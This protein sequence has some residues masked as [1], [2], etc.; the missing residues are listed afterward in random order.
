[1]RLKLRK[2]S[3]LIL[4]GLDLVLHVRIIFAA[5]LQQGDSILQFIHVFDLRVEGLGVRVEILQQTIP[6]V[7]HKDKKDQ[8]GS[9]RVKKSGFAT[10]TMRLLGGSIQDSS[11]SGHFRSAGR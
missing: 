3:V 1:M 5:L 8:K 6:Y 9:K 2:L 4:N 11:P 10:K 7:H